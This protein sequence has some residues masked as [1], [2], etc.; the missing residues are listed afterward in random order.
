MQ[1]ASLIGLLVQFFRGRLAARR[2]ERR[3]E[4]EKRRQEQE[5]ELEKE[6][7]LEKELEFLRK[8]YDET[9]KGKMMQDL[10]TNCTGFVIFWVIGALIF[11]QIE[12]SANVSS[13]A[14]T[15]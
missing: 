9:D 3:R 12:V 14:M 13:N 15:C 5:D 4:F 1:L 6:P 7:N 2:I 11:S 10:L 8:L